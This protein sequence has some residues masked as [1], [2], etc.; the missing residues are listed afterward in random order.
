MLGAALALS[1]CGAPKGGGT[2]AGR[3]HTITINQLAFSP[4]TVTA[5]VGD[6]I[7]WD[8]KDILRHS[9]TA[10]NGAFDVDLQ[11]G[12]TARTVLAAP[13]LVRYVCRYHPGM[14]GVINVASKG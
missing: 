2:A 12:A 5:Q 1:A 14:T 7:V 3:N 13:G 4:Q 8:N 9:A 11:P 10:Q 6:T